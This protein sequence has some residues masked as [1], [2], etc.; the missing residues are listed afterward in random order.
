M[1]PEA[2][3]A[4]YWDIFFFVLCVCFSY[5]IN[6]CGFLSTSNWRPEIII[7]FQKQTH[8]QG[9]IQQQLPAHIT[10]E[11]SGENYQTVKKREKKRKLGASLNNNCPLSFRTHLKLTLNNSQPYQWFRVNPRV[12]AVLLKVSAEV[13]ERW[14]KGRVMKMKIIHAEVLCHTG[15][16]DE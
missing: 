4:R 5:F 8:F 3:S 14:S 9:Y 2:V 15:G 16:S 1:F 6:N 11:S 7:P 12:T 13:H 10:E